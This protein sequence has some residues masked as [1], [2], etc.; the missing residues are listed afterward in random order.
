MDGTATITRYDGDEVAIDARCS[1]SC[2]LVLTDLHYP[3][4]HAYVGETD[5]PVLRVNGLFRGVWLPAGHHHVVYRYEPCSL[6]LGLVIF[7]LGVVV[8]AGVT[9]VWWRGE[10]A[11]AA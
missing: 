5:V 8:V 6:R 3:G 10:R 7:A 9:T 1:A 2:L 11:A 4:W